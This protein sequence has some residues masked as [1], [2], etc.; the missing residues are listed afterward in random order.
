MRLTL[1][2]YASTAHTD[3]PARISA[4]RRVVNENTPHDDLEPLYHDRKAHRPDKHDSSFGSL[5]LPAATHTRLAP[6]QART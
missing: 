1:A 2:V 5:R 3:I 6:P 4:E